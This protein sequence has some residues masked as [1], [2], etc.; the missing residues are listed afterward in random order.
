MGCSITEGQGCWGDS[1]IT[2]P[3]IEKMSKLDPIILERFREHGWPNRVGMKL[4]FDKVINLGRG[5][6][7][8]SGQVKMIYEREYPNYDVSVIWMMTQSTR[9]SFYINEIIKDYQPQFFQDN[10]SKGYLEEI[11]SLQKDPALEHLFYIN[12]LR[13]LCK[14]RNYNLLLCY[15]D[16]YTKIVQS[17]DEYNDDYLY[18]EPTTL[19]PPISK[20]LISPCMHPNEMGYEWIANEIVR[21]VKIKH[22]HFIQGQE[23]DTIEWEWD[24]NPTSLLKNKTNTLL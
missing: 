16:R 17:M 3:S 15:W 23:Q 13:N 18:E 4:G 1:Q 10:M 11:K 2:R 21:M 8:N 14:V 7:S 6:G 5:G 19:F 20:E 22:P 9:F 12:T 24:G